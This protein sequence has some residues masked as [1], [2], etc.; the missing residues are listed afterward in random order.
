MFAGKNA[1]RRG[2]LMVVLCCVM[3]FVFAQDYELVSPDG[4]LKMKVDVSATVQYEVLYDD[5][6]VITPSPI[7]V[8]LNTG[9]VL[10]V[11]GTVEDTHT[12]AAD[13][14]ITRPYGKTPQLR[15]HFNELVIDFTEGY[16][17]ICR[18]YDEGVAYRFQTELGGEVIVVSE[19]ASFNFS[20][21]PGVIF[22]E[23]DAE[24]RS[25]ERD[26]TT[27]ESI[28]QIGS[29]FCITPALFSYAATGMRVVVAESDLLDYPGMY[30]E[31]NG[32]A[33]MKGKWAHY[34]KT[35]SDPNDVYKY[36]RVLTREDFL[37]KTQGTRAYPWR[38]VIVATDDR[39]LLTNELIYKLA[40]PQDVTDVSWIEPGRSAWEWWHDA[41]LD[42]AGIPSGKN[43]LNLALYKYYVDFAAQY[44]LEYITMDAGWDTSY[45]AV[46]CQYA[47]AKGVKVIAWDFINMPVTNLGRILQLKSLGI[48]GI[49]VDLIERDDQE[50]INWFELLAKECAR[51]KMVI[52]FHGCAKP[53]GLQRKYPNI[54]NF[55]AVRGNETTKWDNMADPTYHLQFP[56][57]RMLAGPLDYT[58]G[59]MRNVH[60]SEFHPIDPGVPLT[61]G[62]RAHELAMFVLF[63]QPLAFLCDAPTEYRKYPDIMKFL[64]HVP[65]TWDE[66]L[67]LSAK[68][69]EHAII[70]RR[71]GE[72][73]Y[74]GA[75]TNEDERE[76]EIDFSFLPAG[77]ELLAEVYRDDDRTD[78]NAKWHTYEGIIVT[79]QSKLTL[80]LAKGG[81]AVI[82]IHDLVTGTAP[83]APSRV[84]VYQ[85]A[86]HT[87]LTI[88]SASE[89]IRSVYILDA[90]GKGQYQS[91]L[92]Q[93]QLLQRVDVSAFAPGVYIVRTQ[94]GSKVYTSKFVR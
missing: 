91:T 76:V 12:R 61:I 23:A 24:M 2:G 44:N 74:V 50:A 93:P 5:A 40:S 75:M 3:P 7:S 68:I 53:T 57:I 71:K 38:V 35:V 46:L 27:F 60:P 78:I 72:E 88:Q 20:G 43:N 55:E 6:P 52:V 42:G 47:A 34:P 17:L 48:S 77:V 29:K 28:S 80:R 67:P 94:V 49:K 82:R 10:G 39:A 85:N 92:R 41:I 90:S 86:A 9:L 30:L 59:S 64:S 33:G 84:L 22:P 65:T 58:P 73:W 56:F 31:R 89:D 14:T 87:Q 62:T 21:S 66:T 81:G 69:G 63:D 13:E 79:Q 18:A 19:Q 26:Y 1:A 16:S 70:A 36:H 25:W 45:A 51:Q 4:R 37:A 8:T 11:D 32:S 83:E 15:D 54:L